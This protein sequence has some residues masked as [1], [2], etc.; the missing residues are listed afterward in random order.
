MKMIRKK[1][2]AAALIAC[3]CAI[4][5]LL[6]PASAAEIPPLP[7][8]SAAKVAYLYN[9]DH[10]VAL[11]EKG[12]NEKIFP[13]S[14][15]KIMSGLVA[16]TELAGRLDE[17]ITIT[18]G[19]REDYYSID[20]SLRVGDK[21]TVR[22]LL[23]L[24]FCGCYHD[25]IAVIEHIVAG[26]ANG[27][28]KLMNDRAAE[29]GMENT[30]YT[31]STG[32]YD[33]KMYSTGADIA[34]LAL[35]AQKST[36]YM[37][38]T[39]APDY[40]PEG[41]KN[42]SDPS[43]NNRNYLVGRGRSKDYFNP[44]FR[45]MSAGQNASN[46]FNVVSV[47]VRDGVSYLVMVLGA[48]TDS[49][50]RI[51]SYVLASELAEW[52][53]TSYGEVLLLAD[54]E[55][56]GEI[57]VELGQDVSGVLVVP[58]ESVSTY[59]LLSLAG[60]MERVRVSVKITVPS[61]TAPVTAGTRVGTVTV[62]ID[63]EEYRTVPLVTKTGAARSKLDYFFSRITSFARSRVFI[64]SVVAGAFYTL[65]YLIIRAKNKGK[66]KRSDYYLK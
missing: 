57:P 17:E 18:A 31:N 11:A 32:V 16:V 47:A 19:M 51:L 14:T 60:D 55:I 27:F 45:G 34:R 15:V 38:I 41:L 61:L 12:M 1:W 23:Y 6:V 42:Y 50:G 2:R 53:F 13:S 28:V 10:D 65:I 7:D 62:L 52:A 49:E 40:T 43:F 35:A 64:A 26:G 56:M 3:L 54:S 59:D 33:E 4:F 30:L 9:I 29:L 8:L 25:A 37:T 22:D 58:E 48:P 24:G 46:E 21:L 39:S 36:L 63:G 66:K 20:F 44:V 5:A